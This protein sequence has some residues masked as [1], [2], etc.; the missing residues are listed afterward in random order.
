MKPPQIL[1]ILEFLGEEVYKDKTYE[2]FQKEKQ[3][4]APKATGHTGGPIQWMS[5][6][7]AVA[8]MEKEP[9]AIFVDVYTD[10]C[11]WCKRMDATTFK[12]PV[13]A[14][15]MNKYFYAVKLDAEMK[16]PIVFQGHTFENPNPE[17]R[18]ST[19]TLAASLLD[20]KLSYPSFVMLDSKFQRLQIIPGYRA[21]KEFEPMLAFFGMGKNTQLPYEEFMKSFESKLAATSP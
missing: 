17:G 6:N 7:E 19:H 9:R 20:N 18:R 11:G 21:A 10:W 16:E 12:N 4:P 1:P 5:W 15:Y 8:A 2:E 3:P 13:I 14:D